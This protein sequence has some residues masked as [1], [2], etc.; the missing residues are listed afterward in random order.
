M[1]AS[2]QAADP[3]TSNIEAIF[4]VAFVEYESL[5][6]QDLKKLPLLADF[7]CCSSPDAALDIIRKQARV[8]DGSNGDKLL[9]SLTPVVHIL[10]TFSETLGEGIGLVGSILPAPLCCNECPSSYSAP[11]K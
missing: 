8:L 10:C 6:G 5:A 4:E 3:S 9:K 11:R 2:G 7:D 1:S